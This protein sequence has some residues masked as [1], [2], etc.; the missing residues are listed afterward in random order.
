[1]SYLPIKKLKEQHEDYF[2]KQI[3]F[4][5]EVCDKNEYISEFVH[6]LIY[7]LLSEFE[8]DE[9]E[10][11][12]EIAFLIYDISDIYLDYSFKYTSYYPYNW[13]YELNSFIKFYFLGN[14][15]FSVK[16]DDVFGIWK[17]KEDC[18]KRTQNPLI[19]INAAK[20]NV[21]IKRNLINLRKII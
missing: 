9:Y 16:K 19:L 11:A 6:T 21:I 18:F 2:D 1:M 7:G 15:S 17:A 3:E 10:I 8:C 20:D 5:T 12:K 14:L 13:L 4:L